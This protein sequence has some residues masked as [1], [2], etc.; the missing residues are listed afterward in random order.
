MEHTNL[1]LYEDEAEFLVDYPDGKMNEPVPGVA[2]IRGEEGQLG[3][4]HTNREITTYPITIHSTDKSGVTVAPDRVIQTNPVL[5][6]N[7]VKMNVVAEPVEGYKPRHEVEKVTFTSASTEHTIIYLAP[8]SY[9]I[10]VNHICSGESITDPTEIV[11]EDIYEE[12][13]VR[14]TIE[15]ENVP[16]YTASSV[17]ISV[18]GNMEYDL[19]YEAVVP[20]YEFIDMGFGVLFANKNLGA[21]SV[22]D[23]GDLY[24]WGELTPK[25]AYTWGNYRFGDYDQTGTLTKY[26]YDDGKT[27]LD[28]ED[29]IANVTFGSGYHTLSVGDWY[30]L[31][32]NST[33]E[34]DEDNNCLIFT[35]NENGN[36]L[37]MPLNGGNGGH[38]GGAE[39]IY[40]WTNSVNSYYSYGTATGIGEGC[41]T[42]FGP[43]GS[44]DG[45]YRY[46]GHPI[47]AVRYIDEPQPQ[48]PG[49]DA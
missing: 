41:E 16:G 6:G 28:D 19:E 9:T 31:I 20:E 5:D 43:T 12:D 49:T 7:N 14:V 36:Q 26:C 33:Y 47:R 18:S 8:T 13:I 1:F 23:T 40:F 4:L 37:I 35:S 38:D 17:T 15:P 10:T 30:D 42:S 2:Y 21:A 34:I 29:D 44:C 46:H 48:D 32:E 39:N 25:S 45:A 3:I 22:Y 11:V 24:A 27:I